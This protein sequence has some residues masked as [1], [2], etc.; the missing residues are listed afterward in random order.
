MGARRS[1]NILIPAGATTVALLDLLACLG[2]AHD[3]PSRY[4][5]VW[6][7]VG[8]ITLAVIQWVLYFRRYVD[9]RIDEAMQAQRAPLQADMNV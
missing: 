4:G 8:L 2:M 3:S 7:E 5:M 9:F 6:L 1:P